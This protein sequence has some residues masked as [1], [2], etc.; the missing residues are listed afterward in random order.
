M[1]HTEEGGVA[2]VG[3]AVLAGRAGQGLELLG[4]EGVDVF[5]GS[6]GWVIKEGGGWIAMVGTSGVKA[7]GG[8]KGRMSRR[9]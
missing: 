3:G 2:G 8:W 6:R 7:G 4:V 5:P 9:G 1:E